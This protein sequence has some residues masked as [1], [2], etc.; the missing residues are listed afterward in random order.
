[1]TCDCIACRLA[2][3]LDACLTERGDAGV[4]PAELL[5]ALGQHYGNVL[6]QVPAEHRVRAAAIFM[7]AARSAYDAHEPAPARTAH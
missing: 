1:M 4:S 5:S 6:Q 2:A 3:T 7:G